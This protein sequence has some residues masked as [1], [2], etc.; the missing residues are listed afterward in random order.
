MEN[1]FELTILFTLALVAGIGAQVLANFVGVPS[2]VFLLLFG[3]LLGPDGLSLVHPQTMG[4]GLEALVS[5]A[6]ALILFEGG[7]NLRLQRLNQVSDSL[8]NLVLFGSLLT[9]VGGAVAAHYLGEFPWRLAFLFGSLVVVTGPTVINPI[10][11]RV[12]VDSAVSTLLEGEGV[13]IDPV[14]AILAVV[15]LQV[16]L[17]GHPSFLMALEQLSS[18]LAIGAAV[19][20]LG[21]WLMGSF[22]LWSRQFLTEDLRNSVV[23]AGALGVFV[24]AQSLRSEAGL[25]A[26]VLAGLV[27][28]QKAAIAE[29]SVR[30]FHG[31]LV[32]VAISVLFILL[33]S[34]LSIK[35]VFALG[36]GSVAT[37]V[38][39]M[40][41][42]RPLSIW[43]CTLSSDL[44]WRQKLFVA[45]LAPR[46]IV[47]ASVAS[48]FAILLTERGITGGDAL[49]A[50]VFLTISLT[51][52]VQGLTAAWV[53]RWLGLD[54]GS[55]TVII[56]DH[57][58]TSQLAQLMRSLNQT[59]EVIPLLS[60]Q[61]SPKNGQ[62]GS[63]SNRSAAD[64]A[65]TGAEA[66]GTSSKSSEKLSLT[67]AKST[68]SNGRLPEDPP[69]SE[70]APGSLQEAV[71]SE[72]ALLKADI[73]YAETLLIMT[74][75]PQVNWAIAELMVKLSVSA[76]IWT[77]LLPDMPISEGIRTLQNP[78]PQL[79]RWASY[80]EA[81]RTE[82]RSIT[83]P[84]L[85]DLGLDTTD[86]NLSFTAAKESI[87]AARATL[88]NPFSAQMG[89]GDPV[90]ERLRDQFAYR[91]K[92][93]LCLPLL[94]LRP[95]RLGRWLRGGG[96]R[97]SGDLSQ[98]SRAFYLPEPEIWRRGDRIYYLERIS[99]PVDAAGKANTLTAK[100]SEPLTED[101]DPLGSEPLPQYVDGVKLHF[102]L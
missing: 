13:L 30:Q 73:E 21:G 90:L 31:Q 70:S 25:M 7:L 43:L 74:L 16:V 58:L 23:L 87:S 40:L 35:A 54:Q 18:R 12:R 86:P 9:L 49:K 101:R 24:L 42:I 97:V 3:L 84:T 95:Q 94:L 29:R 62:N 82:L 10:L 22:L 96:V 68:P 99:S 44:N 93:D 48:L 11:K 75:N 45:W 26:V 56:G 69:R 57:P 55:S 79:Q 41:L 89:L 19:G 46:G 61:G 50:L 4:S 51:V 6:V 92:A 53:A 59:V 83:L 27:V 102:D 72:S 98:P 80:V 64:S 15:V 33:T 65:H 1:S 14:G 76:T 63:K 32:V 88:L 100:E 39:L 37:V 66:N 38:C 34:T 60:A 47:A 81:N 5:L 71:L 77:V 36:W 8:R 91:I 85:A 52:T 67:E 28:R 2:I 78:F 20:A 17:S